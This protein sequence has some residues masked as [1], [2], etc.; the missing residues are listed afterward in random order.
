MLDLE[1][2]KYVIQNNLLDGL[3][4]LVGH[5]LERSSELT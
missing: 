1:E 4:E 3:S 5:L 2:H